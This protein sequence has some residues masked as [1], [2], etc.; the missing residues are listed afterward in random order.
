MSLSARD[1]LPLE[2]KRTR[3]TIAPPDQEFPRDTKG[4]SARIPKTSASSGGYRALRNYAFG[5]LDSSIQTEFVAK[6]A[7]ETPRP[8]KEVGTVQSFWTSKS[9]LLDS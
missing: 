7:R 8:R 5:R 6:S 2:K 4:V 9:M 1:C 3:R